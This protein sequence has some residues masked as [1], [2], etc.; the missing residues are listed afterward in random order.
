[1]WLEDKEEEGIDCEFDKIEEHEDS[2]KIMRRNNR[3]YHGRRRGW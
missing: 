3:K 1:L 2:T